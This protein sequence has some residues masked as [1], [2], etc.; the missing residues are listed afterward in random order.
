[1]D[2]LLQ[3]ETTVAKVP[4]TNL[5]QKSWR[6]EIHLGYLLPKCLNYTVTHLKYTYPSI[7]M[8]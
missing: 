8:G 4:T 1:M 2:N 6:S 3:G 5:D 7:L